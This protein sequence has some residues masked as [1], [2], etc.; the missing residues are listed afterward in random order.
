M[1][2][3]RVPSLLPALSIMFAL[4]ACGGR[5]MA[6]PAAES[7]ENA[8]P[9]EE[10][11]E[12]IVIGTITLGFGMIIVDLINNLPFCGQ[13]GLG[14]G[15]ASASLYKN[16]LGFGTKAKV[17]FLSLDCDALGEDGCVER[18]RKALPLD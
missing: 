14:Q 17:N 11:G 3:N 6:A 7:A 13:D 1:K 12:P 16:E 15:S 18:I 8:A 9:A 4:N 2:R 10:R 5:E